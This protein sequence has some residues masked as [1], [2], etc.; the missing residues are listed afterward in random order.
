MSQQRR[1]LVKQLI[2]S[3]N[4]VLVGLLVYN[5]WRHKWTKVNFNQHRF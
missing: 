5:L 1:Y 2:K 3:A 4:V